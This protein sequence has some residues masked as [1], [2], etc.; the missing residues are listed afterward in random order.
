MPMG[1]RVRHISTDIVL[2][3]FRKKEAALESVGFAES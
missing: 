1:S 3:A 2:S